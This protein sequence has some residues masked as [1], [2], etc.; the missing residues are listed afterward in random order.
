M[1]IETIT[2]D[3]SEYEVGL[4]VAEHDMQAVWEIHID[5][6]FVAISDWVDFDDSLEQAQNIIEQ[7]EAKG[8]TP[9]DL[10]KRFE[11]AAA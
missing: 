10:R 1:H 8:H 9:A 6:L 2:T 4:Q 5:G 7:M 3:Y 11:E